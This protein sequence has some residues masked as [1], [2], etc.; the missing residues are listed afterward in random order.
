MM[1]TG[2][3]GM[4]FFWGLFRHHKLTINNTVN[5]CRDEGNGDQVVEMEID[6]IGGEHVGR[7]DMVVPR[8]PL[9]AP[10]K[11]E[12]E[13]FNDIAVPR[14]PLLLAPPKMGKE[15]G[16]DDIA[17]PR[18]PPGFEYIYGSKVQ[19]SDPSAAETKGFG[20]CLQVQK[21]GEDNSVAASSKPKK[22]LGLNVF[23]QQ[24]TLKK[25]KSEL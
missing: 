6:M 8:I 5:Q 3:N 13:S 19:I 2:W 17:I 22:S 24:Q 11:V 23:Q 18:I 9:L 4:Y 15:P 1:F 20:A 14:M 25:V 21:P 16:Y 10:S 12:N 7:V